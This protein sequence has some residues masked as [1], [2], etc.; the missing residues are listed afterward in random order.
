MMC[1]MIRVL[2]VD[3]HAI[4][5]RAFTRLLRLQPDIEV[6]GEAGD[7]N[8]AVE[9]SRALQPDIV[10]MDVNMPIMG[11]I[12]ATRLIHVE[13]PSVRVIGLSM[14]DSAEEA[15]PMLD[16]GAVAYVSKDKGSEVLLAAIRR[17]AT[18]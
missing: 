9:Q 4:V 15:Q 14:F 16:A 7:G 18:A 1:G 3:D 6:I 5:R 2:V 10:L 8:A 13:C 17:C 11:G 12:E